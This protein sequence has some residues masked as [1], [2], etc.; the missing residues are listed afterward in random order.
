MKALVKEPMKKRRD[1]LGE[2][3]RAFDLEIIYVFGGYAGDALKWLFSRRKRLQN[4][5]WR[6]ECNL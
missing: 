5:E 4:D 1:K 3:A 6:C 2:I